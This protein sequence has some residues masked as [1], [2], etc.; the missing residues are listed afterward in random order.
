MQTQPSPATTSAPLTPPLPGQ[1]WPEQH[2]RYAGIMCSEDGLIAW[3]L[4][5]P[6]GDEYSF[7]CSK[8]GPSKNIPGC[9]SR[10][11][12]HANTLAMAK[13]G[14]ALAK[15]I[16]ALPGDCY[17]PARAE[18]ALM[19]AT[20]PAHCPSGWYWTSTQYSDD[21]AW[22]QYF[23]YGNQ[24]YGLKTYEARARAVR[25]LPLQSFDTSVEVAA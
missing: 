6:D 20:M 15:A 21:F 11:D 16:R 18:T 8:W 14:S 10:F 17:L 23:H 19:Y 1:H 9:S 25:R 12:G 22:G 2:G 5:V 7:A 24:D 3:H 4:I 13:G